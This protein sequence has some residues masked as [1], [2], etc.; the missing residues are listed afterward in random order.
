MPAECGRLP[1][2]RSQAP[3]AQ[4]YGCHTASQVCVLQ[5]HRCCAP[6]PQVRALQPHRCA[7]LCP[8]AYR[9]R[10]GST[11][12][13]PAKQQP[14]GGL[15]GARAFQ[16]LDFLSFELWPSSSPELRSD[17]VGS[18]FPCTCGRFL[19]LCRAAA[20][21]AATAPP[22]SQG[23]QVPLPPAT[24]PGPAGSRRAW[25][26]PLTSRACSLS[27][28]SSLDFYFRDVCPQHRTVNAGQ[29][30]SSLPAVPHS[31]PRRRH[32]RHPAGGDGDSAW[33]TVSE[34]LRSVTPPLSARWALAVTAAETGGRHPALALAWPRP[35]S[36]PR[37]LGSP[38]RGR[39]A[40]GGVPAT[41][42]A[43][44]PGPLLVSLQAQPGAGLSWAP[45]PLRSPEPGVPH[46]V[47]GPPWPSVRAGDSG[48][49]TAA[50][51]PARPVHESFP[52]KGLRANPGSQLATHRCSSSQ[53]PGHEGPAALARRLLEDGG[54]GHVISC[55]I[56]YY[57][58]PDAPYGDSTFMHLVTRSPQ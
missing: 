45:T 53:G 49:V 12:F 48:A 55:F 4:P 37:G 40:L 13:S 51:S 8:A 16:R 7:P 19:P 58:S 5:P 54:G 41:E 32:R 24:A 20:A 22:A 23:S 52:R 57:T 15:D 56:R 50:S 33:D 2:P 43:R 35:S 1:P 38:T 29:A 27:L 25:P 39:T 18:L 26:A 14:T 46:R 44:Q 42:G 17:P 31:E 28:S 34:R 6:A 10:S 21:E 3:C 9:V 30:A 47:E 36:D 11:S